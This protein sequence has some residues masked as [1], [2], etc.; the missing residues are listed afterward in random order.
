MSLLTMF[1]NTN[2]MSCSN[3]YYDFFIN[4][5]PVTLVLLLLATIAYE[6]ITVCVVYSRDDLRVV[7]I[8]ITKLLL[9][10]FPLTYYTA[11]A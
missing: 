10:H 1:F 8:I 3:I 4:S 11:I 9:S 7:K 5:N 6:I 2:G